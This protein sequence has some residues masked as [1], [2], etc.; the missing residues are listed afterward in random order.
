MS[1]LRARMKKIEKAL[2]SA[3]PGEGADGRRKSQ[4]IPTEVLRT[5]PLSVRLQM[6]DATRRYEAEHPEQVKSG[7]IPLDVLDLPDDLKRQIIEA[8]THGSWQGAPD[9]PQ[10]CEQSA[11]APEEAPSQLPTKVEKLATTPLPE[12]PANRA[13][14]STVEDNRHPK[15]QQR[16]R[17]FRPAPIREVFG[18]PEPLWRRLW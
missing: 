16:K 7:A 12:K 3:G 14:V 13:P 10:Y 2:T 9:P 6:L 1:N 11:S 8:V 4:L 15:P 5:L 17:V 18:I